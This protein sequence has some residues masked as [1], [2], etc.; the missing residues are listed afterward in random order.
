MYACALTSYCMLYREYL[1]RPIAHCLKANASVKCHHGNNRPADDNQLMCWLKRG[2]ICEH[3]IQMFT[4]QMLD[5]LLK[6]ISWQNSAK[7]SR[8]NHRQ[9]GQ[10]L[11]CVMCYPVMFTQVLMIVGTFFLL[12]NP[13]EAERCWVISHLFSAPMCSSLTNV[14]QT[15][16]A[17]H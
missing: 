8:D 10:M 7:F 17:F 6:V 2:L 13:N 14:S 5:I 16:Q 15:L 11:L 4:T 1:N 3:N 12:N 9:K